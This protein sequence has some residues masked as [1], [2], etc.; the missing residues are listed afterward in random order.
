[1]ASVVNFGFDPND[2]VTP[3]VALARASLAAAAATPSVKRLVHTSSSSAAP[4]GASPAPFDLHPDQYNES[5]VAE[6]WAPPPYG[7]DRIMSVY[8]AS[9]VQ[10]E[11]EVW[12]FVEAQKPHFV[13]NTV[14]PDFVNGKILS[15]EEQ[16]YPSSISALK[17]IWQG[18]LEFASILPPQYEIDAEDA[19]MLHVAA[20]CKYLNKYFGAIDLID[21]FSGKMDVVLGFDQ[22]LTCTT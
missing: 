13:V 12:R 4:F 7:P 8:A 2:V 3:A 14:L 18:N 6:A 9:K 22:M 17:A 15:V 20:M 1:M 19:G 21:Y 11:Q 16:G 5:A 10:Q